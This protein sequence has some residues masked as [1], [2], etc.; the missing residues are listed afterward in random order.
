M[1]FQF[2]RPVDA[3]AFAG[4]TGVEVISNRDGRTRLALTGPVGP[5]LRVA[6]GLNPIDMTARPADL[7]ELFLRYYRPAAGGPRRGDPR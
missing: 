2:D 5:L 3:D 4:L 7:D 6:A 1:E